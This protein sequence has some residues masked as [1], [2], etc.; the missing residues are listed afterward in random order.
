M[1]GVTGPGLAWPRTLGSAAWLAYGAF[2]CRSRPGKSASQNPKSSAAAVVA[3]M[4]RSAPMFGPC[5]VRNMHR[6][7]LLCL[8]CVLCLCAGL[9]RAQGITVAV[10]GALLDSNHAVWS[11][12]VQLA[13]GRGACF[14]IFATGS[15]QPDESAAAIAANLARHGA[16]GEAIRVGPRIEGQDAAAAVLAA[17]DPAWAAKVRG[18]RGVFFSGG[19]QA[20]ILDTLMPGGAETPLLQAVRDVWRGGGV[21]AG[22][23][24]GAAVLS[25]IA[26][27]DAADVLAVMKGRLREGQEWARG[28]GLVPTSVIIDQH[29]IRRGRIARLLPLMQATGTP[30][31]V[32]VEE[33]SAAIFRGDEVEVVGASGVLIADLSQATRNSKLPAF[34]LQGATLHWLQHGDRYDLATRRMTPAVP[35]ARLLEPLST[36]YKGYHTGALFMADLLAEGRLVQAMARLVDSDQRELRGLAFEARPAQGDPAPEL[37]FEWRLWVDAGTRGWLTLQP[38]AYSLSGLRLDIAP[39]RMAQPLYTPLY[40]PLTAKER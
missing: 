6:C 38:E 16:R 39:V 30:L 33:D 19:A 25:A 22:T 4:T 8:A 2:A 24:S 29:F 27:R 17:G 10:G 15:G 18:C 36:G 9:V 12:L 31:G 34:N 20:R 7:R 5:L 28:F 21:V 35:G 26:L 40:T 11:R 13:G 3:K 37:G 1:D 23:S 14:A 32:G